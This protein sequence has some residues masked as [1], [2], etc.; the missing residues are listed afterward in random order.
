MI[1]RIAP[2]TEAMTTENSTKDKGQSRRPRGGGRRSNNRSKNGSRSRRG[3]TRNNSNRRRKSNAQPKK[4]SLWDMLLA[5]FGLGDKKGKSKSNG[6]AKTRGSRAGKNGRSASSSD[7]ESRA[8]PEAKPRT[9]RTEQEPV[10]VTSPKLY[11]GNLAYDLAES[12]LFDLFSNAGSVKN[13]EI[14]RD[15]NSNSKGFGFVEMQ[16][17]DTAKE[18]VEKYNRHDFMGR[19]LVVSGAKQN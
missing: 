17:L 9:P 18:A 16:S 14:V 12:D 2:N 8:R 1:I 6:S 11:V 5:F 10:E 13:V 7:K 4:K 19:Q 15:R 3:S